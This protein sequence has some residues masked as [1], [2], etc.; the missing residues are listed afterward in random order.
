[1]NRLI[2]QILGWIALQYSDQIFLILK[3]RI[4][5]KQGKVAKAVRKSTSVERNSDRFSD[6]ELAAVKVHIRSSSQRR[7]SRKKDPEAE[8]PGEV[9]GLSEAVPLI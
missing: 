4:H 9:G 3:R 7:R 5:G 1:M 8:V 6:E 2:R